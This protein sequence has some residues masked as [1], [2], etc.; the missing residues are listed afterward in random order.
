[1]NDIVMHFNYKFIRNSKNKLKDILLNIEFA[2]YGGI[3]KHGF[4]L[5]IE[6]I[7]S[8]N[9]LEA[10]RTV[11]NTNTDYVEPENG[12]GSKTVFQVVPD[13]TKLTPIQYNN[14]NPIFYNT[15]STEAEH[16]TVKVTFHITLINAITFDASKAPFNPFIFRTSSDQNAAQI[17]RAHETHLIDH[18]PTA[19]ADT[20]LFGTQNDAS[21]SAE[22]KYYRTKTGLPWALEISGKVSHVSEHTD[23]TKA[24]PDMAAWA[25]S[26]G[27]NN[28]NWFENKQTTHTWKGR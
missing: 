26:N 9:I 13:I 16:A 4:G 20:T 27:A 17:F 15:Q 8:S 18:A 22:G 3:I 11:E 14:G 12:Q 7:D 19:L 25:Q 2:A 1:M 21:N 28:K 23:F 24:Y 10:K 5:E 6:G